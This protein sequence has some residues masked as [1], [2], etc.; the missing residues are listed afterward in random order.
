MTVPS[1]TLRINSTADMSVDSPTVT[2]DTSDE[3]SLKNHTSS[4]THDPSHTQHDYELACEASSSDNATKQPKPKKTFKLVYADIR[5]YLTPWNIFSLVL[6]FVIIVSGAIL[7]MALVGML[8]FSTKEVKNLWIEVNSQILNTIFTFNAL[9]VQP[10]RAWLIYCTIKYRLALGRFRKILNIQGDEEAAAALSKLDADTYRTSQIDS[11]FENM[12]LWAGRIQSKVNAIHLFSG[13]DFR[14]STSTV[15]VDQAVSNEVLPNTS[16]TVYPPATAVD[17][18]HASN[19]DLQQ[20]VYSVHTPF[21]T[22]VAIL[23][24]LNGQCFF[25]YPIDYGMWAWA[26][27]YNSRPPWIVGTFLPLSFLSGA[28]GGIWPMLIARKAKRAAAVHSEH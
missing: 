20:K 22:W 17:M 23:A 16:K 28:I 14:A 5:P 19:P 26:V 12:A 24:F 10:E 7:F 1:H 2:I 25:Q 9:V 11:A 6:L 8:R 27:D 13:Y 15:A 18:G 4:Q 21:Y 3:V